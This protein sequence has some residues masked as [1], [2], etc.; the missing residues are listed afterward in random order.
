MVKAVEDSTRL[1]A[2][3]ATGWP[4]TAWASR[5]R[6]DPLK[7]L[8]LNLGAEAKV[9][10]GAARTSVPEATQVQRARVDSAVRDLVDDA[11]AGLKQN[12]A[13]SVR[14]ASVQRLPDLNDRLDRALA[15]TDL[16]ADR[17]PAWAQAVRVLQWILIISAV[18]GAAWLLLLTLGASAGLGD[19][20]TPEVLGWPL[21]LLLLAAGVGLGVLLALFSRLL[22]SLTARRRARVAEDRLRSAIHEVSEELVV[23]PVRAEVQAYADTRA[24]IEAALR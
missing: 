5:F 6:P 15:T 9:L 3:R 7:R 24:G 13:H 10:T 19:V 21:P 20:A 22:V 18:A 2:N 11:T 17:V 16:G 14:A 12:W 1:R 8:H 23:E 4:V